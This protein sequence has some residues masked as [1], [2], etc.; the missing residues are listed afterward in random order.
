MRTPLIGAVC[1]GFTFTITSVARSQQ[2]VSAASRQR[3]Q[4]AAQHQRGLRDD[5]CARCR[6]WVGGVDNTTVY[7][8]DPEATTAPNDYR[9]RP[10]SW[11]DAGFM[12]VVYYSSP[13]VVY[14][15]HQLRSDPPPTWTQ[16]QRDSIRREAC[17]AVNLQFGTNRPC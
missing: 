3:S 16:A 5:G 11:Y 4:V 10:V 8:L 13:G 1:L 9:G 2:G 14:A 15:S 6:V 7:I 17:L 12:R